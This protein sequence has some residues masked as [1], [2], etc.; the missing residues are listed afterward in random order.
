MKTYQQTEEAIKYIKEGNIG[1][2]GRCREGNPT[3]I[4]RVKGLKLNK[5]TKMDVLNALKFVMYIMRKYMMVPYYCEQFNMF[6]GKKFITKI[7]DFENLGMGGVKLTAVKPIV[8][9][10]DG[11]FKCQLGKSI[12]YNPSYSAY[13]LFKLVLKL[14]NGPRLEKAMVI[15]KNQ[16]N[17]LH[18]YFAP[19]YQE[20]KY[21]GQL[22]NVGEN[23]EDFWPP[24]NHCSNVGL[25]KPVT[26]QQLTEHNIQQ[27]YI[28][29]AETDEKLCPGEKIAEIIE[30]KILFCIIFQ[31]HSLLRKILKTQQKNHIS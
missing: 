19:E 13:L 16:N 2:V 21:G 18:K 1:V 3:L 15:K 5:D 29:N 30:S 24:S 14:F 23:G 12:I 22:E 31:N 10:L 9:F 7:I 11:H 20:K 6:I 26:L 17:E 25:D 28:V 4:I 8:E 27:F